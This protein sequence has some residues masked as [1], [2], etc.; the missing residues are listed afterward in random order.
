MRSHQVT[1]S[2]GALH[3]PPL[4]TPDGRVARQVDGGGASKTSR[5][6]LDLESV[7][8]TL[9]GVSEAVQKGL[10][11]AVPTRLG[12]PLRCNKGW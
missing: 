11:K 6:K 8:R 3:G 4:L 12:S 7:S 1:A 10:V 9:D 5:R 2:H